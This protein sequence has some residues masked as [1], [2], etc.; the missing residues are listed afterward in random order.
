MKAFR[1]PMPSTFMTSSLSLRR[2][3]ARVRGRT[4]AGA[5]RRA[6]PPFG[7]RARAGAGGGAACAPPAR[8]RDPPPGR[9]LPA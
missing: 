5:S 9:P 1:R 2:S 7:C 6:G 8:Q 3:C 4:R